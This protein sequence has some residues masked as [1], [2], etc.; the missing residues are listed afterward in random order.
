MHYLKVNVLK[1]ND[2]IRLTTENGMTDIKVSELPTGS[3]ISAGTK[4]I[5]GK[6]TVLKAMIVKIV[7]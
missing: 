4:C 7:K 3:S 1:Q 5:S 2:S 6:D